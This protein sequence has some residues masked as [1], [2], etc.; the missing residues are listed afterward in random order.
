MM[1]GGILDERRFERL[2]R[3]QLDALYGYIASR[4]SE[5]DAED[6]LQETLLS[7]WRSFSG[8]D[9]RSSVKTWLISIARRRICDFYRLRELPE[10][11]LDGIEIASGADLESDTA[12]R[13]D[14]SA[15]LRYLSPAERE[16][17]TLV[18]DSGLSYAEVSEVLLIPVGTVKSRMSSIR[19]KLKTILG[20]G[21][22]EL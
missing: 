22:Y 15:A 3:P 17:V 21:Y 7:A 9:G 16:L 1:D 11:G 2:C 10:Y 13:L 6:I 12:E 19:A 14:A 8:F 4:V 5:N 18:F 20:E